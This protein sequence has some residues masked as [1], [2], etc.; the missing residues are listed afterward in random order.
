MRS[1]FSAWIA[2]SSTRR[3][4]RY[5]WASSNSAPTICGLR[6]TAS[7]C[8]L[9]ASGSAFRIRWIVPSTKCAEAD[10]GAVSTAFCAAPSAAS[11]WFCWARSL[12]LATRASVFDDSFISTSSSSCSAAAR[13]PRA[14]ARLE[15]RI[16]AEAN[17]GRFWLG[18]LLEQRRCFIDTLRPDVII[19]ERQRAL[20][21]RKYVRQHLD[22]RFRRADP[23]RGEVK[24]GHRL[25]GYG[26]FRVK[27]QRGLELRLS[28]GLIAKG[29]QELRQRELCLDRLR[30]DLDGLLECP[31]GFGAIPRIA[32]TT[33][34]AA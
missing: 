28:F 15:S 4:A 3:I 21:T 11:S 24:Q 16:F 8:A 13:S 12:D 10:S 29:E 27:S 33:P 14:R 34:R 9:M 18:Q 1:A 7:P 20:S 2:A 26:V 31:L 23:A 25:V 17:V 30:I 22:V 6:R 5:K 19:G 32:R